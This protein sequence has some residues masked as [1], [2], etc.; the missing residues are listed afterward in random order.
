MQDFYKRLNLPADASEDQ[1]RQRLA[2]ADPSI[3]AAA[4]TIL[5]DARRRQV[6]DRNREVLFTIGQLRLKLGLNY[7]R[8]W[9]RREYRDF[10]QDGLYEPPQSEPQRRLK[11]V[12]KMMIAQAFH[13]VG[14]R[15][16]RHAARWGWG[17][18]AAAGGGAVILFALIL[19]RS[20]G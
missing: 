14:R 18:I 8:F 15:G 4:Q 7:T 19:W 11:K 13:A 6:Y 16:R 10:W 20:V 9:A 1:I 2:M 3:R 5:L 12:D 17:W